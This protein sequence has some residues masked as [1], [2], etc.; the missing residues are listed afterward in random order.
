M[1]YTQLSDWK[2]NYKPDKEERKLISGN[3]HFHS[4]ILT[5]SEFLTALQQGH[6][7]APLQRREVNGQA[8]GKTN[9]IVFDFDHQT[10]PIEQFIKTLK[11]KPSYTY[12]SFS[13]GC[14]EGLYRY[15][16]I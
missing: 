10:A 4:K 3:R 13:N 7:F 14:E 16:L 5:E 6:G 2:R 8:H 11:I 15:R 9:L 12:Y 1:I